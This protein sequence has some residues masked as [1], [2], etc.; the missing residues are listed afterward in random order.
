MQRERLQSVFIQER[1][2]MDM[3]MDKYYERIDKSDLPVC[4]KNRL[5][6]FIEYIKNQIEDKF[7]EYGI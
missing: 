7:K 1:A 2:I 4:K 3:D 5:R 6:R